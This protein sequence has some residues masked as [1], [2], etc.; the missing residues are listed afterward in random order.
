MRSNVQKA[1]FYNAFSS[2]FSV[3]ST[4]TFIDKAQHG[5]RRRIINQALAV[6][7]LKGMERLMLD[8]IRKFC[9]QLVD[10]EPQDAAELP[11][12]EWSTCKNMTDWFARLT[13]DIVGDL[14]FGR[15]WNVVDSERNRSFLKNIPAGT[16]GLLLV[17]PV[18]FGSVPSARSF[19]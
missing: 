8:N 17:S 14:S 9:D 16:A 15:N 1:K 18:F 2:F 19:Y 12:R 13:F 10:T 6:S 5:F 4:I 3:P 11:S 7:A